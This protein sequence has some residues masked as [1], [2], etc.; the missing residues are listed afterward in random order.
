MPLMN[1]ALLLS[2]PVFSETFIVRRHG[3]EVDEN[4]IAYEQFYD[5]EV[6]GVVV[7]FAG[8]GERIATAE[9]ERQADDLQIFTTYGLTLGNN[10]PDPDHPS[11]LSSGD[12][13][14][15][16]DTEWILTD[17]MDWSSFGFIEARAVLKPID[18]APAQVGSW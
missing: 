6:V 9:G 18:A 15:W 2:D 5:T 8:P 1:L 13:V 17:I 10:R 7:P 12:T 4:G 16:H 14:L 3:Q 11:R